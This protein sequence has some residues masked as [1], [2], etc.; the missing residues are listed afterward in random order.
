MD[1]FLLDNLEGFM[2][3]N[4]LERIIMLF[5]EPFIKSTIE[6]IIFIENNS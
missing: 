2:N 3:F 6:F 1:F 4:T 5:I